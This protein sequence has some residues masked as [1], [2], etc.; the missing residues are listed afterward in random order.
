M[1]PRAKNEGFLCE[2]V[3]HRAGGEAAKEQRRRA[4][5]ERAGGLNAAKGRVREQEREE[6]L[7][8]RGFEA[9]RRGESEREGLCV[10]EREQEQ[11]REVFVRRRGRSGARGNRSRS[12]SRR[13]G[14]SRSRSGRSGRSAANLRGFSKGEQGVRSGLP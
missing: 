10:G 1:E 13:S 9:S 6:K 11:G 7:Q 4:A 12:R 3:V 2:S 5:R 8:V 14:R